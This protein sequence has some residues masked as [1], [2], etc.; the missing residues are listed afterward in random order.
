MVKSATDL[1]L[2]HFTISDSKVEIQTYFL[3]MKFE[4]CFAQK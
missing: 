1:Q 3:K 4:K 2:I